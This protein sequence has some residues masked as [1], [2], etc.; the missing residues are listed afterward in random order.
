MNELDLIRKQLVT[1]RRRAAEVAQACARAAH[2]RWETDE[3]RQARVDYLV[4]VLSRFEE[5]DQILADLY[6]ARLGDAQDRG[7]LE[8][9]MHGPG[10]SREVLVKLEAALAANGAA[11]APDRWRQFAE[12]FDG[13]WR[14]RR[15]AVDALLER[16]PRVTDWRAVSFVDADS[17]VEERAL[18]ACTQSAGSRLLP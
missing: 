17:I 1:E 3:L 18:Y 11:E 9:L 14:A 12:D 2:D 7:R 6:R 8:A 4:F 15:D 5:R 16:N 13:P 10:A